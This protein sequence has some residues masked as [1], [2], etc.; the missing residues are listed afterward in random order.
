[1]AYHRVEYRP[2]LAEEWEGELAAEVSTRTPDR[3]RWVEIKVYHLDDGGWLA[4]RAGMSNIYHRS[5]TACRRANGRK[6]GTLGTVDDL[7]DDAEPCGDCN[8]PYPEELGDKEKIRFEGPQHTID[9]GTPAQIMQA[10][11]T[12]RDAVTGQR[13]VRVSAPVED[14]LG[15]LMEH[16][17]EFAA[18]GLPAEGSRGP[19]DQGEDNDAGD[20][21]PGG[22]PPPD[23]AHGQAASGRRT[24]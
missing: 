21:L 2:G 9:R 18:L 14:L 20:D 4:H 3:T 6:P 16:Y 22:N 19:L 5:A 11:T 24:G 15:D 10:L 13:V 23:R 7:P 1:M 12:S 8:P 17:P